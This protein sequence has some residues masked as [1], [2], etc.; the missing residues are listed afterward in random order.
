MA[1]AVLPRVLIE[2]YLSALRA[3]SDARRL[4]VRSG[5]AVLVLVSI[6]ALFPF[7]GVECRWVR[8]AAQRDPDGTFDL[9]ISTQNTHSGRYTDRLSSLRGRP[10]PHDGQREAT[11]RRWHDNGDHGLLRARGRL[12]GRQEEETGVAFDPDA[13]GVIPTPGLS[14]PG[15]PPPDRPRTRRLP[16]SH[17]KVTPRQAETG[18]LPAIRLPATLHIGT[19][20]QAPERTEDPAG[21]KGPKRSLKD[22]TDA[23]PRN[24]RTPDEPD[25]HGGPVPTEGAVPD[26]AAA[27]ARRRAAP[28]R[29]DSQGG[30]PGRAA[31]PWKRPPGSREAPR[32]E[33][34]PEPPPDPRQDPGQNTAAAGPPHPNPP[35]PSRPRQA[36]RPRQAPGLGDGCGCGSAAR[37]RGC[38]RCS[39]SRA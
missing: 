2:V 1:L 18:T 33:P 36:A 15:Q 24:P 39:R 3:Q 26:E 13:T 20:P 4:A 9:Q 12:H 6:L 11:G 32:C 28:D 37:P 17:A 16:P 7:A 5:L 8:L 19:P 21:H 31:W 29:A 38:P 14:G 23:R 30:R 25:A 10:G 22:P 35:P 34:P 27:A